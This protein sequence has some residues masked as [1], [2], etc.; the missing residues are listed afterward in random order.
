MRMSIISWYGL[1]AFFVAGVIHGA[2]LPQAVTASQPASNVAQNGIAVPTAVQTAPAPSNNVQAV[3]PQQAQSVVTQPQPSVG[4][5]QPITSVP[6]QNVVIPPPVTMQPAVIPIAPITVQPVVPH[7]QAPVVVSQQPVATVVP[8]AQ[9]VVQQPVA[10]TPQSTAISAPVQTQPV[11]SVVPTPPVPM[12]VTPTQ[13]QAE[14]A[15]Q[16]PASIEADD[17]AGIPNIDNVDLS[18]AA[19][20]W[21]LK[22]VWRE[23]GNERYTKI[24]ARMD[25]LLRLRTSFFKKKSELEREVTDPFYLDIGIE[26]G[27]LM[28][29]LDYIVAEISQLRDRAGSLNQQEREFLEMIGT[30]GKATLEQLQ[31]N[32]KAVNEVDNAVED[33]LSVLSDQYNLCRTYEKNAWDNLT[34][35]ERVLSDKKAGEL[36]WSMNTHYKNISDMIDY[37]QQ[38]FSDYFQKLVTSIKDHT[39][40]I[41]DAM[42]KLK[43][44]GLDF[45]QRA[46]VLKDQ[47]EQRIKTESEP[48]VKQEEA[49][50]GVW[51][52]IKQFGIDIYSTISGW[53]SSAYNAVTGLFTKVATESVE[54]HQESAAVEAVPEVPVVEDVVRIVEEVQPQEVKLEGVREV[55]DQNVITPSAEKTEPPMSAVE[56]KEVIAAPESSEHVSE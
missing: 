46:Q 26:Q 35:I 16:K 44:K 28:V 11:I 34:E 25:D 1:S 52:R 50:V 3:A 4:S 39:N 15:V 9:P 12:Q 47:A 5:V 20:N 13:Q 49:T 40:Q 31:K 29:I 36:Y 48:E 51:E 45:K 23:K 43:E 6:Q 55:T 54:H 53:F 8:V 7:V 38:P 27:E 41:K 30:E 42:H 17:Q 19:G 10:G 22:R 33:A 37:V 2:N 32:I 14:G 56:H 21:F 24:R 18:G